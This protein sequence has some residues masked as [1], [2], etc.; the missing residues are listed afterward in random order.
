MTDNMP[1]LAAHLRRE[2]E[3]KRRQARQ[4][5]DQDRFNLAADLRAEADALLADADDVSQD[6]PL[7]VTA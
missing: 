3:E 6:R 1:G 4:A 5:V 2:S 7:A